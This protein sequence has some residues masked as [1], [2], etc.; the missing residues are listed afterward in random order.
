MVVEIESGLMEY[1]LLVP[2]KY[3][4]LIEDS[5]EIQLKKL[6]MEVFGVFLH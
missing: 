3:G 2:E 6:K 4:L 5:M 1:Q